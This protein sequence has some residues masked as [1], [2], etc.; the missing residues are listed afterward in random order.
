MWFLYQNV[1]L[2][3][4]KSYHWLLNE[5][6]D[7][8]QLPHSNIVSSFRSIGNCIILTENPLWLLYH[9]E[10][11]CL[12]RHNKSQ[13]WVANFVISVSQSFNNFANHGVG[14]LIENQQEGYKNRQC[15]KYAVTP[16]IYERV[17]M[18]NGRPSLKSGIKVYCPRN[19]HEF[20]VL[21]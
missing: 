5:L 13:G 3:D 6:N 19:G 9:V 1:T 20:L 8:Y 18:C 16:L 17:L 10:I 11:V 21:Q 14:F 2:T 7:L 12:N 15:K 4:Q